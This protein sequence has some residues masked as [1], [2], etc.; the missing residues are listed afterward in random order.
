MAVAPVEVFAARRSGDWLSWDET[1]DLAKRL[2]LATVLWTEWN[3]LECYIRL[4][5]MQ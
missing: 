1:R 3:L 4:V 5:S 2:G